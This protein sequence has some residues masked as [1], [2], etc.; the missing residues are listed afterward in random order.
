MTDIIQE[1]RKYWGNDYNCS[2]AAAR[3]ILDYFDH[4]ELSETIDKALY[5]FGGGIGEGSICGAVTGALAALSTIMVEKDIDDENKREVFRKFKDIFIEKND[6]LYC[7]EILKN[8]F[9]SDGSVDYDHPERRQKC[10]HAVE[11]A[12][13]IAKELIEKM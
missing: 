11:S 13:L 6:T 1:T 7:K 10:D 12:V 4:K 8:F 9:L 3:G 5:A 2:R